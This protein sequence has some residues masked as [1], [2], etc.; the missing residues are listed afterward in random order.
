MKKFKIKDIFAREIL[1][2]RGN[3]TIET[4]VT[5][6]NGAK[7]VAAVPS[8]AS[9]G[10]YEAHELRDKDKNRYNGK[11]VLLAVENVNTK[12]KNELIGKVAND[13][14]FI[15]E[16]LIKLDGTKNK[17]NLGANAILSVS[18]ATAKAVANA[19]SLSLYAYIGD[20]C[21]T[22]PVPMC[23]IINGGEHAGNNIDIQEFM[24]MPVGA[25]SFSEGIRWCV[26]IFH[27]LKA[28][29]K[30]KGLSTAV[31][32]EGGFAANLKTAEEAL[33]NIIEAVKKANYKPGKDIMIA[34]DAAA[35]GW[36]TDDGNYFLPKSKLKY[37]VDELIAYW[38]N[39]VKKYPII[40]LE[41][42]LGENDHAG[43]KKLTAL[44]GK[45][46]QIVGDDLFVT[47]TERLKQGIENKS[48]N[49]ILIKLNQIGTLT[50]TLDAIKLAQSAGFTT[51]ISHRSGETEDTTIADL[52]V[53]T[54]STQIKT[55]SLC[56]SE[57]V[58]KYNRLLAIEL[59]L[60]PNANY[61]GISAFYQ[62]K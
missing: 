17:S 32:D 60:A 53:A 57:R 35:S 50:E 24:I 16:L 14:R 25:S 61:S 54:N 3:P 34:I 38:K 11:G 48:A 30:N 10:I 59:D 44:I 46:V 51:V 52:A 39:L 45:K 42:P 58:A 43:F 13:Q 20:N 40:S 36:A 41:D 12:I 28:V 33:D 2:S 47:N 18:L 55:G 56:R 4:C 49:S 23:N 37:T 1:D 22:L 19:K 27:S 5:L 31:G 29:L 9:T 62:L 7:G 26:E 15:D 8:G 6:N 21:K